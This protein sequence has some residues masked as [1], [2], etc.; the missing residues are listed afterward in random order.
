[1]VRRRWRKWIVEDMSHLAIQEH[2][3]VKTVE[4]PEP[5]S[6]EQVRG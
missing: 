5:V 6:D 3:E 1:M 2:L 4:R